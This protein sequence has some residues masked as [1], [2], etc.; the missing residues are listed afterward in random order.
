MS[1]GFKSDLRPELE[2]RRRNRLRARLTAILVIGVVCFTT[3]GGFAAAGSTGST[4]A[5]SAT[6]QYG[7]PCPTNFYFTGILCLPSPIP[8][9]WVLQSGLGWVFTGHIWVLEVGPQTWQF[10]V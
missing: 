5:S 9:H 10:I 2:P 1:Q 3:A 7:G 8:G 4:N 6:V